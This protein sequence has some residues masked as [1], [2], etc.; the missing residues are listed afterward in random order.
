MLSYEQLKERPREFLSVTGLKRA[1]FESLL[2][3][4]VQAYERK[5]RGEKTQAQSARKRRAGGGC[6]GRLSHDSD[7]LLFILVYLKTNPLQ[8]L[9]GLTFGLSQGQ[10][11][12]WIHHLLP[13][14]RPPLPLL[15]HTL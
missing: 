2:C 4:F 11:N 15:A 1:E 9:H 5:Y 7:K 14:V 6:K 10:T 13:V 12:F 3:A 8:T